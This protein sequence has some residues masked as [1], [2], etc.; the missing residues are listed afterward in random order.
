MLMHGDFSPKKMLVYT[1]HPLVENAIRAIASA[2][3]RHNKA[4]AATC[5]TLERAKELIAISVGLLFHGADI[6]IVKNDLEQIRK[7]IAQQLGVQL[8]NPMQMHQQTHIP[9]HWIRSMRTQSL[10]PSKAPCRSVASLTC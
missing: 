4:W 3:K 5:G 9:Q 7:D 1:G 6:V 2:A 10:D 8:R